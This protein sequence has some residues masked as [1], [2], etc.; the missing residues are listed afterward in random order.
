ML[1]N[2]Y[3]HLSDAVGHFSNVLERRMINEKEDK[4][5]QKTPRN[6]LSEVA[7][8][9][10]TL[11]IQPRSAGTVG[12]NIWLRSHDTM[13]HTLKALPVTGHVMLGYASSWAMLSKTTTPV[14]GKDDRKGAKK[15]MT[16]RAR[17]QQL[18]RPVL[19]TFHF[20]LF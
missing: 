20:S 13:P 18:H 10:D 16:Y 6:P 12:E 15:M 19:V 2:L 14:L 9:K 8:G 1:R 5:N 4:N 11:Q 17:L 3:P 7:Q